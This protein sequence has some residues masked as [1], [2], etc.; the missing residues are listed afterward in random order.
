[1]NDECNRVWEVHD[2]VRIV[3]ARNDY[4]SGFFPTDHSLR[5]FT[6]CPPARF[7][8]CVDNCEDSSASIKPKT[9]DVEFY[10]ISISYQV[11]GLWEAFLSK[12]FC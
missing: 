3:F 4:L 7:I 1:M 2:I 6:F 10:F 5:I 9:T 8:L 12:I 11:V